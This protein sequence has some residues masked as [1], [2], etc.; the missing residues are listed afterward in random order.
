MKQQV[1][2]L[3]VFF[4][5]I[6]ATARGQQQQVKHFAKCYFDKEWELTAKKRHKYYRIAQTVDT[7]LYITDYYKDGTKQFEGK[8]VWKDSVDLSMRYLGNMPHQHALDTAMFYDK[9]GRPSKR[10]VYLPLG[11]P[12][13][14]ATP[15]TIDHTEFYESGKPSCV[16]KAVNGKEEG[17]VSWLAEEDGTPVVTLEMKNGKAHGTRTDYYT[18]NTI[19]STTDFVEGQKHGFYTEYYRYPFKMKYR[20]K[21]VYG[22]LEWRESY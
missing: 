17:L 19:Y 3:L 5:L 14:T 22:Q 6:A 11:Q 16:W 7:V 21:Y 12:C 8:W 15:Y 18:D 9:K 1:L 20:E 13:N 2:K 4:C 10:M